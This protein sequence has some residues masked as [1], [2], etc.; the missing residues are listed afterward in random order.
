MVGFLKTSMQPHYQHLI[1]SIFSIL[2]AVHD[3]DSSTNNLLSYT[4]SNRYSL[5]RLQNMAM[6]E[7]T[8]QFLKMS[9]SMLNL[10]T[11]LFMNSDLIKFHITAIYNKRKLFNERLNKME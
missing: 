7:I 9:V 4:Y 11:H 5:S 10:C 1:V 8:F 6:E 2:N 3:H